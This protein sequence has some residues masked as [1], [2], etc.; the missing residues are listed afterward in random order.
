MAPGQPLSVA[1]RLYIY[2]VH[3]FVAEVIFTAMWQLIAH[4]NIQLPGNTSVWAFPIYG[5]STLGIEC[6]YVRL[7][8]RL[9][10]V[11]RAVVYTLWAYF[12]EFVAGWLLGLANAR[13]WDYTPFEGHIMGIITLEYAPLWFLAVIISETIIIRH[14]LQLRWAVAPC[15]D[16]L[17]KDK[18]Q[19]SN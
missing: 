4:G 17:V 18:L 11:A 12:C 8:K 6:M 16:G 9:P 13:P 7:H 10:M 19:W 15:S 2:A 5:V 1:Y 14:T 3:G